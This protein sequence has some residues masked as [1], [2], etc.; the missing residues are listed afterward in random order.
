MKNADLRYLW[1]E[2]NR[3]DLDVQGKVRFR[4]FAIEFEIQKGTDSNP[5]GRSLP[6]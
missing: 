3:G 6:L 2:E 4:I 5:D 1:N